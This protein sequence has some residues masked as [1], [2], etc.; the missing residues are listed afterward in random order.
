MVFFPKILGSR[1]RSLRGAARP[2]SVA[3]ITS[4]PS[5]EVP[6]RGGWRVG[7]WGEKEQRGVL[8]G[9]EK[10]NHWKET[11]KTEKDIENMENK[12]KHRVESVFDRF[13]PK[14]T[15]CGVFQELVCVF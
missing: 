6:G 11:W 4:R 8:G 1:R 2:T 5:E 14:F 9:A 15:N 3:P 13:L 10:N 12:K 7:R